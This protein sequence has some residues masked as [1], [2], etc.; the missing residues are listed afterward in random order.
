LYR[1][2]EGAPVTELLV[3]CERY[4]AVEAFRAIALTVGMYTLIS[5]FYTLGLKAPGF[6]T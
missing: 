3:L 4:Q 2:V 1:Y 6:T 5:L